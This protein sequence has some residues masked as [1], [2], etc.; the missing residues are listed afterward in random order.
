MNAPSSLTRDISPPRTAKRRKKYDSSSP[1]QTHLPTRNLGPALATIEAG[2]AKIDD[3]LAHFTSCLANAARQTAVDVPRLDIKEYSTLYENNQHKHGNHFVVHQHNHPRAGVHYDLRLQFSESSSMSFAIPKGLPGD[4]NS[5]SIGRMAIETRVH[6]Y[7]NHLIESASTK[8]GSL[9]IWDTGTY[10]VLPRTKEINRRGIPSPQTT[11]DENETSDPDGNGTASPAQKTHE[12]QNLIAAFQTRYI[13]L[14][15]HGTRLPHNYTVTLRLPTNET[16]QRPPARRQ[17]KKR[18]QPQ[19]LNDSPDPD[20]EQQ[21]PL[22]HPDPDENF[23]TDTDEDSRT[24]ATNAYPG[25]SNTIGSVHQ[26]RWFLQ[27]DRQH[28][29]FMLA[30]SGTGQP[31]WNRGPDGGGFAP[32]LVRGRDYERSVVTGRLARDVESDEGVKGFKG[33]KGWVGIER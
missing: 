19:R 30:G 10:E 1:I 23:D 16:T 7:W 13:R 31:A 22:R 12:N 25:A 17:S 15:L 26:R 5:K 8:T 28:S 24:R 20:I 32:F 27:L 21:H 6:N 11:D 9:L 29:G 14:R 4:A 3:H 18:P 2:T 33:R